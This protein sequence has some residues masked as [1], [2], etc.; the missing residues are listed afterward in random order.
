MRGENRPDPESIDWIVL[1]PNYLN[2]LDKGV[3]VSAL[4][5][6]GRLLEPGEQPPPPEGLDFGQFADPEEWNVIINR[7]DLLIVERLR[8]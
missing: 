4:T 3:L 8:N 1:E 7:P 2:D 5:D 6:P